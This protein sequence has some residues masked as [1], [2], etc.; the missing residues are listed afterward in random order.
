[1]SF[2]TPPTTIRLAEVIEPLHGLERPQHYGQE[3]LCDPLVPHSTYW[4][5][6]AV[7]ELMAVVAQR[8]ERAWEGRQ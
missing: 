4:Y 6:E 2:R 5:L 3:Q 8:L 7:P 1:L